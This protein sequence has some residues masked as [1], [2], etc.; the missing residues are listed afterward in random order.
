MAQLF[1]QHRP[2]LQ[3]AQPS[4]EN[5]ASD[6]VACGSE[7]GALWMEAQCLRCSCPAGGACAVPCHCP[8]LKQWTVSVCWL[9]SRLFFSGKKS[10]QLS[11]CC[12]MPLKD[13]VLRKKER[14]KKSVLFCFAEDLG[15]MWATSSQ[16]EC[17]KTASQHQGR[18]AIAVLERCTSLII[19]DVAVCNPTFHEVTFCVNEWK[20]IAYKLIFFLKYKLRL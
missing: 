2:G 11:T 7:P 20:A 4:E 8:R 14:K 18:C 1:A 3:P 16:C 13:S 9:E 12:Q 19:F 5:T 15:L 6:P 17:V 10:T